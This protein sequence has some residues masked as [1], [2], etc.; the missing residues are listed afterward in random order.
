MTCQQAKIAAGTLEEKREENAADAFDSDPAEDVV[1]PVGK[2]RWTKTTD[3]RHTA[4][5]KNWPDPGFS[6]YVNRTPFYIL[7]ATILPDT[8]AFYYSSWP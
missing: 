2:G 8:Q 5:Q 1:C 3:A 7:D 6:A 4:K